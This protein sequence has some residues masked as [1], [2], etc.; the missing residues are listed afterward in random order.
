MM[1]ASIHGLQTDT[2]LADEGEER[3]KEGPEIYGPGL[4]EP[5]LTSITLHWPELSPMTSL[6]CKNAE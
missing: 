4:E 2:N 5:S 1:E 3:K 6:W